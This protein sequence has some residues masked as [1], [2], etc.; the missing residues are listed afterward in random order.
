MIRSEAC[1]PPQQR[2]QIGE[3]RGHAGDI[4]APRQRL[5]RQLHRLRQGH[6]ETD[7]ALAEAAL[8]RHAVKRLFG[9]IDL[10]CGRKIDG[11]F[12]GGVD[13]VLADA[14]QLAPHR[15]IGQDARIILDVGNGGRGTRETDE[16]GLA[17]DFG[18]PGVLLHQRLQGERRDGVALRPHAFDRVVQTLMQRI[19]E[20]V[21][22]EHRRDALKRIIVDEDRAEK[23]LLDV[24][25]IR[26]L[27]DNVLIHN[28]PTTCDDA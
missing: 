14:D 10:A 23:R 20:M 22:L 9:F 3:A 17:A 8:F 13:D 21:G 25:I 28:F 16:I 24:D 12:I 26:K 11:R 4:A 1:R 5:F 18:E 2:I 7:R 27:A 19:V 6:I 15:K